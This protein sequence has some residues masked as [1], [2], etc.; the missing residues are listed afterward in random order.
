MSL[1]YS[2]SGHSIS[3]SHWPFGVRISISIFWSQATSLKSQEIR[4]V[5]LYLK[6]SLSDFRLHVAASIIKLC[7]TKDILFSFHSV[8]VNIRSS[9]KWLIWSFCSMELNYNLNNIQISLDSVQWEESIHHKLDVMRTSTARKVLNLVT[10]VL[11]AF[12]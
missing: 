8:I 10:F 7:V 9:Y 2:L 12:W 3:C 4:N 6:L 1:F 5:V 11:T